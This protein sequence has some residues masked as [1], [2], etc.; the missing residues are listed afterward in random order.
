MK[1]MKTAVLDVL[2]CLMK[3]IISFIS[4]YILMEY[5]KQK[6]LQFIVL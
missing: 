6:S 5:F 3:S 2:I 4:N 1:S